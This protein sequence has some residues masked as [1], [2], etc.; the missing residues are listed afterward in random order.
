MKHRLL[1]V[2]LSVLLMAAVL[3]GG[4]LAFFTDE[5]ATGLNSVVSG[6]LDIEVQFSTD[7]G[8]TW[9]KL[10]SLTEDQQI[11]D[12]NLTAPGDYDSAKLRILNK[13]N[14]HLKYQMTIVAPA[15][16]IVLGTSQTGDAIDLSKALLTA[17]VPADGTSNTTVADYVTGK[18]SGFAI[19]E[20]V[21]EGVLAPEAF[22]E[23]ELAVYAPVTLGNEFN[24][25]SDPEHD[26]LTYRPYVDLGIFVA[27]TQQTA[28]PDSFDDTYDKDAEYPTVP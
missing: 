18:A 5:E 19:G 1:T 21:Y 9:Q 25:K 4:T 15:E 24:F 13:G 27:A 6:T 14:L 2:C 7:G 11:L 20:T 22:H 17:A 23:L 10:D 28:E 12:G 3:I 16:G 8:T 26:N